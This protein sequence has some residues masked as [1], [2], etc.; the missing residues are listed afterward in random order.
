[1]TD[2]KIPNEDLPVLPGWVGVGGAAAILGTSR[3]YAFRLF[4]QRKFRTL[5]RVDGSHSVVVSTKE[6]EEYMASR[7]TGN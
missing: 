6:L 4:K 3:Q 2:E 1:M 7:E 5:H